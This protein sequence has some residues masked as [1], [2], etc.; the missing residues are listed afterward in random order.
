MV[1][2]SLLELP[3]SFF[4]ALDQTQNFLEFL[5]EL[6]DDADFARLIEIAMHT[7]ELDCPAELWREEPG[8]PGRADEAILTLVVNIRSGLHP[9]LYRSSDLFNTLT[10]VAEVLSHLV[11]IDDDFSGRIIECSKY[12][13]VVRLLFEIGSNVHPTFPIT[14]NALFCTW[15]DL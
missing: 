13:V 5:R 7:A 15:R 2:E 8:K 10:E 11:D 4:I 6:P 14:L 1:P 3:L 12:G 9:L